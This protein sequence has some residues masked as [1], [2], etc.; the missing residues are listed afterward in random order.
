[1]PK[2]TKV[3]GMAS[4]SG[5]LPLAGLQGRS[6]PGYYKDGSEILVPQE[7]KNPRRLTPEECR[8]LMGFPDWYETK[9][10]VSDM[11]DL[12][13]VRQLCSGS[14]RSEGGRCPRPVHPWSSRSCHLASIRNGYAA[15][16][17]PGLRET[18]GTFR[19]GTPKT[20]YQVLLAE[21][22]VQRTRAEQAARAWSEFIR[23]FP[24]LES[25]GGRP[26][27][28]SGSCSDLSAFS[29]ALTTSA[30]FL[31]SSPM[32]GALR[33]PSSWSGCRVSV[34]TRR[35]PL[36]TVAFGETVGVADANVVRIWSR[37]LGLEMD[38]WTRRR[39]EFLEMC[40]QITPRHRPAD[41]YGHL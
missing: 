14:R 9:G 26:L 38:D 17:C 11:A 30:R 5:S 18:K 1:M 13:A 39:P 34:N 15:N 16:S 4:V 12:Q 2:S 21:M 25:L 36:R 6:R 32:V 27:R 31:N 28:K 8:R 29:G 10:V 24:T 22:M 41:S 35:E 33:R 7:G 40:R 19:G 23:V 20:P 37:F 3:S